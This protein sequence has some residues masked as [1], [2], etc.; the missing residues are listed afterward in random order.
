MN[1]STRREAAYQKENN[2]T[3]YGDDIAPAREIDERAGGCFD[4]TDKADWR[5]RRRSRKTFSA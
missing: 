4:P 3:F 2:P 1:E 5:T